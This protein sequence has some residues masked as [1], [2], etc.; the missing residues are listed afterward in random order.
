MERTVSSISDQKLNA[1]EYF[2][3]G[4]HEYTEQ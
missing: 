3:I 2:F 1:N 4:I